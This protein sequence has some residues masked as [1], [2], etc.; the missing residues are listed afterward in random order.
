MKKPILEILALVFLVTTSL[1]AQVVPGH[2]EK[3][4]AQKQG[5]ELTLILHS[6]EPVY[7]LLEEVTHDT[8]ILIEEGGGQKSVTKVSIHR[9]ETTRIDSTRNGTWIGLG[10]GGAAGSI[11]G[12][13]FA[14]ALSETPT[15][16][17]YLGGALICGAIG[18]GIGAAIG[19]G[20]DKGVDHKGPEL[21]Y[22]AN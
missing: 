18:A 14:T 8:V 5:T 7:G 22:V 9:V 16:S 2:W 11:S 21:L 12:A 13:F 1:Q 17:D 10:I 19:Y 15:A 3:V 6:G 20:V 4:E